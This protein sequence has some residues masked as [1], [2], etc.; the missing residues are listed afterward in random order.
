LHL[1]IDGTVSNDLL[2]HFL[3]RGV[4]VTLTNKV[5][6]LDLGVWLTILIVRAFIALSFTNVWSTFLG[7]HV[8]VLLHETM[9]EWPTTV[10]T[11]VHIVAGH[12]VL[13]RE[14]GNFFTIFDFHSVLRNLGE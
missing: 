5:G 7:Y 1:T 4:T 3:F 14:L 12:E 8:A 11:L 10:T 6:V 9:E 2:H 13:G